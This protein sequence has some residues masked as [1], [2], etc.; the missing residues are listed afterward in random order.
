L[1]RAIHV[2]LIN[3]KRRRSTKPKDTYPYMYDDSIVLFSIGAHLYTYPGLTSTQNSEMFWGILDT[4]L[5][6]PKRSIATMF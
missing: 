4:F 2:N 1:H 6:L 3:P 5:A